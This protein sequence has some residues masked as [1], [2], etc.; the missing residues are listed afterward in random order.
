[1]FR[2]IRGGRRWV[3]SSFRPTKLNGL[4]P[5]TWF[6]QAGSRLIALLI[7]DDCRICGRPLEGAEPAPVCRECLKSPEILTEAECFCLQCRTPF[8]NARPLNED[9]ICRLCSAGATAFDAIYSAGDYAGILRDLIHM[10]KYERM[11]PLSLP[12]GRI[13]AR[14]L[15]RDL[16][17]DAIVPVPIHWRKLLMRGFNQSR[18]LAAELARRTGIPVESPLRR[19]KH[20][21]PQVGMSRAQRRRNVVGAFAVRSGAP[22]Q[23]RRFLLIDDVFTTGSTVNAAA[24][25][26]RN[27]G[28][29]RI[30]VLTLARANRLAEMSD[31][32]EREMEAIREGESR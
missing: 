24:R 23:G 20:V 3:F 7:P 31:A 30:S 26:L 6:R 27:A 12:L 11:R 28:A 4:L 5:A 8:F 16:V 29:A 1:M 25:A 32:W 17:F 19:A 13:L 15:P 21:P 10:F 9:G 18:L 22:I 2:V 14:N